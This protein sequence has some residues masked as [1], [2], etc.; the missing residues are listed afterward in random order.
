MLIWTPFPDMLPEMAKPPASTQRK[1]LS[2]YRSRL[3]RR[4]VVRVEVHVR[5]DDA[6]LVR[7]IVKALADPE[8]EREVRAMLLERLGAGGTSLKQLLAAAPLEGIEL[9]RERD[10]GRDEEL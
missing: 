6:V 5:R 3:K 8:R 7:G 2:S 10:M 9:E 4:G 1:A